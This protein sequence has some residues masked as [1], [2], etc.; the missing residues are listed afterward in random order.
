[1]KN[2]ISV[3]RRLV[4]EQKKGKKYIFS[5]LWIRIPD[6]SAIRILKEQ[7]IDQ[8]HQNIIIKIFMREDFFVK[9]SD[10]SEFVSLCFAGKISLEKYILLLK[11]I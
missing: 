9:Q 7:N 1:M 2:P 3:A 8:S 4:E 6:F 5:V 11:T 10:E